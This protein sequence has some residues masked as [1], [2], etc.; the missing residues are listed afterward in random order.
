MK[1]LRAKVIFWGLAGCLILW[2]RGADLPVDSLLDMSASES[3][4]INDSLQMPEPSAES[5]NAGDTLQNVVLPP[6]STADIS[7][8]STEIQPD[9][10]Y[11][12]DWFW[13]A[14]GDLC[15]ADSVLLYDP[16]APGNGTGEE[17]DSVF[18]N[19]GYSLGPPDHQDSTNGFVSLGSGGTLILEFKDN[20]FFDQ[21]GPDLYF[22]MPD[23]LPEEAQI[24]ISQDGIIFQQAG[25]VSSEAPFLDISGVAEPGEFYT[26]IKIRDVFT[27]GGNDRPSSGSD[28]DAVA[29]IH[30][31][32]VKVLSTENL[33]DPMGTTIKKE[34]SERLQSVA[35]LIRKYPGGQVLIEVYTEN[36]G[37]RDY[38][39]L[40]S[41]KWAK[42]I[43]D[44]F[45]RDADIRVVRFSAV[46]LG[47]SRQ[48]LD[49]HRR[50][51]DIGG[52]AAIIIYK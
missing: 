18:Q 41:Q 4:A 39:L 11:S 5:F 42:E 33:F 31:A 3:L 8:D 6:D 46:G 45:L 52:K 2:G 49:P 20:V 47:N 21:S 13:L 43:R 34:A 38:N 10:V 26:V 1:N 16:G 40:L 14:M 36:I 30:T 51:N 7:L 19:A 35:D 12:T 50:D 27:Q 15:F 22:W 32:I 25:I 28:I 44:F 23:T 48:F 37:T 24:W 17:P 9:F 29:A